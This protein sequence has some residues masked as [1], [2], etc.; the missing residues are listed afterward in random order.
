MN[1]GAGAVLTLGGGVTFTATGNPT[2]TQQ[3]NGPGTLD[4]GAATRTFTVGDST[5][6][7]ID[8]QIAAVVNGGAAIG[9]T[10]AGAGT[11]QLSGNN[12]FS[13]TAT[14]SA[15]TLILSGSNTASSYV[16][17]GG[18]SSV[19]RIT[20]ASQGT[21]PL[22]AATG[23]TTPVFQLNIDG[24]GSNEVITLANPFISNSGI[25]PTINVNNNG[26]SN[27]NNTIQITA[28]TAANTIGTGTITVTGANGYTLQFLNGLTSTAGTV[29]T[30]TLNPTTANLL[31]GG[32]ATTHTTGTDIWA[33]DG[34]STG[35]VITGAIVQGTGTNL[36]QINK[37]NTSTWT[38]AGTSNHTGATNIQNGSLVL[39]GGTNRMSTT[40]AGAFIVTLGSGTTSGRLVFGNSSGAGPPN[41]EPVG[42]GRRARHL[43]HR[44]GQ[45]HRRRRRQRRPRRE[46]LHPHAQHRRRLHKH[47]RRPHRRPRPV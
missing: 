32:F 39:A 45:C 30:Q 46:Q 47:L 34:T 7:T 31:V 3:I 23:A 25:N 18:T 19:L 17:S 44:H 1:L 41:A 13:G 35:N 38:L 10:K 8:M 36:F 43:R 27:V 33:L 37:T 21:G 5:G 16:I 22:N 14:V 28:A 9:L 15:G 42:R 11:L 29:G 6:D 4:L 40:G 20:N 24:G 26:S 12:T 2:A